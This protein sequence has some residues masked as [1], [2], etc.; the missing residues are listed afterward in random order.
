MFSALKRSDFSAWVTLFAFIKYIMGWRKWDDIDCEKSHILW[1][2]TTAAINIRHVRQ[3]FLVNS[4]SKS[5][6]AQRMPFSI[7]ILLKRILYGVQMQDTQTWGYS[8]EE[9]TSTVLPLHW[10]AKPPVVEFV[11]STPVTMDLSH[12]IFLSSLT[13]PLSQF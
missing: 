8:V 13:F 4:P 1:C 12:S 5:Y 10:F 2:L 9:Q 11:C 3:K 6:K 7:H